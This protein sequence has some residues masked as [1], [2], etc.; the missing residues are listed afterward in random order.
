MIKYVFLD[1]LCQLNEKLNYQQLTDLIN[2][3]KIEIFN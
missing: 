1:E 2:S 3:L